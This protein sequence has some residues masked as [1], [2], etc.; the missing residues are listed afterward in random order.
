MSR[1]LDKRMHQSRAR[2]G[3]VLGA[4][5]GERK[6][7]PLATSPIRCALDDGSMENSTSANAGPSDRRRSGGNGGRVGAQRALSSPIAG[8]AKVPR[9][10]PSQSLPKPVPTDPAAAAQSE[11]ISME[12]RASRMFVVGSAAPM[13][14][15]A[16]RAA[17]K[18]TKQLVSDAHSVVYGW[19]KHHI[20]ALSQCF[21]NFDRVVGLGW[22]VS[23][24]LGSAL[25][26]RADAYLIG[27]QCRNA[28]S[29]SLTLCML[30][31]CIK[32]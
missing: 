3:S 4:T 2:A 31:T 6:S 13:A 10:A 25:V 26:T 8:G 28:I 30:T 12:E 29:M 15:Q 9:R 5:S 23:D 16:T 22:L 19:T 17:S 20:T 7:S 11:A 14:S 32:G 27:L 24:A 1:A 21:G 18:A